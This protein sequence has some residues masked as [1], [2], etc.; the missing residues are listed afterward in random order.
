MS[1][2]NFYSVIDIQNESQIAIQ[3]VLIYLPLFYNTILLHLMVQEVL[4]QQAIGE[5]VLEHVDVD[6]KGC[7]ERTK[8]LQML[9]DSVNLANE[10]DI[11]GEK[12]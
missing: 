1:V 4:L 10:Y 8:E 5:L 9:Q 11:I 7:R 3:L 2:H 12:M 6:P